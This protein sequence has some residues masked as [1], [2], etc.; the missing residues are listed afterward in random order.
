MV[1]SICC[2]RFEGQFNQISRKKKRNSIYGSGSSMIF[3]EKRL[4]LQGSMI[5]VTLKH[6]KYEL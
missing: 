1:V 2:F 4:P 3:A 5:A 6:R